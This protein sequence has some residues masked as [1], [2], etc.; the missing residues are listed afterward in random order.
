MANPILE[1]WAQDTIHRQLDAAGDALAAFCQRPR[2]AKCLHETR[3]QLARLRTALEDLGGLA[4]VTPEFVGRVHD[5]H[6]R[7][8]KVRDADVLLERIAKYRDNAFGDEVPQL[9]TVC[10]TLRKRRKRARRKFQR[11]TGNAPAEIARS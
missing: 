5:L 3:K 6:R 2:S 11:A 10:A 7:A 4:G 8:G 9:K 1:A